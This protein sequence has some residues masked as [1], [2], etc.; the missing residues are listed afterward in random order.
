MRSTQED[1]AVNV[2]VCHSTQ[3]RTR[4]LPCRLSSRVS[5]GK[6]GPIAGQNSDGLGSVALAMPNSGER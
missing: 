6:T 4:L 1:H 2:V 5:G 3:A